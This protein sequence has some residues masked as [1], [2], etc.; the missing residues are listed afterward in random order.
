MSTHILRF[1][2]ILSDWYWHIAITVMVVVYHTD[3][4]VILNGIC[5]VY[6]ECYF[7]Y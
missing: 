5:F 4:V 3:S 7:S 2:E 1:F 6:C